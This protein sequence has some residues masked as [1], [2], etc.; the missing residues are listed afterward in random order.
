MRMRSLAAALAAV[1]VAAAGCGGGNTSGSGGGGG[2]G[3]KFDLAQSGTLTVCSDIPYAPME[4]EGENGYT[5]FDIDLIR[6]VGKQ[7]D[8]DVSIKDVGFDG[9]E[10]GTAFK[11]NTCDVGASSMTITAERDKNLDFSDPYFDADQSL[12]VPEK[13]SV[14][15]IEDLSG[16]TVGVQQ[17]T[18]GE[19]YTEEHAPKDAKIVSYPTDAELSSALAAGQIDGMLQDLV[20]NQRHASSGDPVPAKI[21]DTFKTDEHYGFAVAEKGSAKLLDGINKALKKLHE[22]GTYDKLYDEYFS[23]DSGGGATESS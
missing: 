7:M 11:A 8:L 14:A 6:A 13:S 1:A 3:A 16:K 5:G 19:D 15:S 21:V 4:M 9:L 2:S 17:A 18:T 12:M 22:N 23:T 10:S 20:A